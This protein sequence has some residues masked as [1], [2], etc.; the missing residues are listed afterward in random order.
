MSLEE[1]RRQALDFI[2]RSPRPYRPGD[3][4]QVAE[5]IGDFVP[6]QSFNTISYF[7]SRVAAYQLTEADINSVYGREIRFSSWETQQPTRVHWSSTS[8]PYNFDIAEPQQ[9]KVI[10]KVGRYKQF[11]LTK[12]GMSYAK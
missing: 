5:P 1:I 2:G 11:K 8:D 3:V 10:P 7:E 4:I 9:V 6:Y 12:D